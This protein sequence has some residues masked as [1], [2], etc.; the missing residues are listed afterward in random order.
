M[1]GTPEPHKPRRIRAKVLLL[2]LLCA[3]IVA[4]VVTAVL[5]LTG[6]GSPSAEAQFAAAPAVSGGRFS[7]TTSGAKADTITIK[8]GVLEAG[9]HATWFRWTA[10]AGGWAYIT[11]TVAGG[12]AP[13]V[14]AYIGT[15]IDK[16]TRVDT[17]AGSSAG[18]A[19][20]AVAGQTYN[21]A[22][23]GTGGAKFDLSITQ[24][25]HGTAANDQPAG[26]TGI[27]RTVETASQTGKAQTVAVD[28]LAGA[29]ADSGEPQRG[30]AAARHSVWFVWRAQS[31]GK[32]S[33]TAEP[34]YGG[35]GPFRVA[36]YA[37]SERDTT[38]GMAYSELSLVG[39]AGTFRASPGTGYLI[40][41]DGPESFY[42]LKV[43]A[44]GIASGVDTEPPVVTCG[45]APTA[46][47]ADEVIQVACTAAD[48]GDG[49]A[50]PQDAKF[51]LTASSVAGSEDSSVSTGSRPVCD[52][53]GNCATAGP[54][55]GLKSDRKAPVVTCAPA[56]QTWQPTAP[57]VP[58]TA[59]DEGSGL[60]KPADADRAF[61]AAFPEGTE[62]QA[63]ISGTICDVAGNC[64]KVGPLG[65]VLVDR[66][67]PVATCDSPP[68]G[69][70]HAEVAITCTVVDGGSGLVVAGDADVSLSTSVG[71]GNTVTGAKTDAR[72]VCDLAGNCTS[73][74]PFGPF[75][76]DLAPPSVTCT[77]DDG[78]AVDAWRSAPFTFGCD[79]RDLGLG[80]LPGTPSRVT[81]TANLAAGTESD[82]VSAVAGSGAQ[83]CD[84]AGGCAPVGPIT[85]LKIDRKAPEI[86]CPDTADTWAA[87]T[88]AVTCSVT[89]EGSGLTS[90]GSVT[91]TATQAAGRAGKLSSNSKNVC[92]A[93]GNCAAAGPVGL[94]VDSAPPVIS[95][96]DPAPLYRVE[97]R[98]NCTAVD[99]GSG[100][101]NPDDAAFTLVT[102]VGAGNADP[103]AKTGGRQVCDSAGLCAEA[104][105]I[106]VN[107][108]LTKPPGDGPAIPVPR[109]VTVL[110]AD[111]TANGTAVW[112]ALPRVEGA[113][114][115][116]CRARPGS[117]FAF[118]WSSVVCEAVAPLGIS[119]ATFP[120]V[121][122]TVPEL[123]A[124]GQAT[125]GA[126]WRAVGVG[127]GP[128]SK[129]QVQIDTTTVL[130][131]TA[132]LDGRV[133]EAFV[134][135][136]TLSTGDHH[137]VL[138]GTD[139]AGQPLL[140]QSSLTAVAAAPGKALPAGVPGAAP[141]LPA[142]GLSVP[143]DPG[144]APAAPAFQRGDWSSP[145]TAGK[146]SAGEAW[147]KSPAWIV[148]GAGLVL[149]A[150][151]LVGWLLARRSR[152]SRTQA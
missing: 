103:A 114:S 15:E 55:T 41:L 128:G 90:P 16:L 50:H 149:A 152:R 29:T 113:D 83:V 135:P 97:S 116:D 129:V 34:A 18:A 142:G 140:V 30:G 79:V 43:S 20:P 109:K 139:E 96:A 105:P 11:P 8:A 19:L 136:A 59:V 54:V 147:W 143:A 148:G 46:W 92:D 1:T 81:L 124:D 115:V 27:G 100:L 95:C 71:A 63:T 127:F 9:E 123:A 126:Q 7:G 39:P 28:T 52:L 13:P 70:Q 84:R 78:K 32:V 86:A 122:K 25:S 137:L 2:V 68:S 33:F 23:I 35:T 91:L 75:Q 76:L 94:L 120:V 66:K 58:C 150:L 144:P 93:A 62:G 133:E 3:A 151:L 36:V 107:V 38:P 56:P 49:L 102:L 37:T 138:R 44:S 42:T 125:P 88:G 106:T 145:Q 117:A 98:I 73:V 80:L 131:M 40:A 110:T 65:P 61:T 45:K 64:A 121:V 12:Q 112:Y 22:V 101:A 74:G 26:A 119:Y 85:G 134:V 130:T 69:P 24:P 141:E 111:D 99:T 47:T 72:K 17:T 118:G 60:A 82:A 57:S 14:R 21:L 108:D 51:V 31:A 87:K 5:L 48:S 10:P 89:D 146:A 53:S 6:G 77:P 132:G 104:G 4:G 67:P